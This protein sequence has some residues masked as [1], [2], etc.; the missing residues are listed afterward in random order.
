M[1][2]SEVRKRVRQAIARAKQADAER[3]VRRDEAARVYETFLAESATPI[4]RQVADS[5]K[6]E[7]Y[8]FTVS[9]PAGAV[10]LGSDHAPED[11]IELSLDTTGDEPEIVGRV[12][13]GRGRRMLRA[14]HRIGE[15]R[16]LSQLTDADVLA[17]VEEAIATF[18]QR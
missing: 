4:F 14:E 18:L 9:T 15:G 3:R 16:A 10:R 6:A 5:L 7:G 11:F 1:E 8:P 2:V 12:S 17:F 13:R